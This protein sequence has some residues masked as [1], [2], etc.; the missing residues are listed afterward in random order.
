MY[1]DAPNYKPAQDSNVKKEMSQSL[2]LC[3]FDHYSPLHEQGGKLK[4][5]L[6]LQMSSLLRSGRNRDKSLND[7]KTP[8][9]FLALSLS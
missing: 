9:A 6:H 5:L 3:S 4:K 1:A 2:L 8:W 7:G